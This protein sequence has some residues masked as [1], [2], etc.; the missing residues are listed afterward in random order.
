MRRE[1]TASVPAETIGRWIN[2]ESGI[3]EAR[4]VGDYFYQG[5]LTETWTFSD[6]P[7]R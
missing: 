7:K 2:D 5:L 4:A 3:R 6:V 1:Q